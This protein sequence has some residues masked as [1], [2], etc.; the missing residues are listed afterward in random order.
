MRLQQGDMER[1][2]RYDSSPS[3]RAAVFEAEGARFL[4][5]VDLDGACEG[6]S[7]N[8]A[9]VEEIIAAV[10]IPVQLGGGLRSLASIEAWLE[11]GVERVVVSTMA[12]E[13][14]A[15]ALEACQRYRERLALALD[16]RDGVLWG[17]GWTKALK[18]QI[19]PQDF[20]RLFAEQGLGTVIV[21]DIERDGTMTGVNHNLYREIASAT[22]VQVIA[23]GGVA[24]LRDIERLAGAGC[25]EGVI[26]G[27]ALY[28]RKFSL[29]QA[30]AAA[31]QGAGA[32]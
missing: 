6:G 15:L 14:E 11:R 7:R 22:E 29:A 25:I 24:S 12:L 32:C 2:T 5:V 26:C 3:R 17:R 31:E 4:H 13:D 28:E 30:I 23:S 1:A 9:A 8:R 19:A 20:L 27:R 10:S 16:I 18:R 21:T